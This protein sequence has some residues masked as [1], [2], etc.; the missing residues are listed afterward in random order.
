MTL[1]SYASDSFQQAYKIPLNHYPQEG[2]ST[3]FP[4]IDSNQFTSRII[5]SAL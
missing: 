3:A 2:S 1:F 4:T 5:S